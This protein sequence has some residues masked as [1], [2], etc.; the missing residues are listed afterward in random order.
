MASLAVIRAR[1]PADDVTRGMKFAG[2]GATGVAVNFVTLAL[3]HEL[4]G[5]PL[6]LAVPIA[7]EVSIVNN[8]VWNNAWTFVGR[9]PSGGSFLKFNASCLT[10]LVICT[11]TVHLL[12][13]SAGVHYA[14][15]NLAGIVLGAAS[16]F[17][18]SSAWAWPKRSVA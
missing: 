18:L 14:F 2:V 4:L 8:F 11:A 7:V 12:V 15:A 6:L 3:L 1:V 9:H 16:N 5:L 10:G 17:V 13:A